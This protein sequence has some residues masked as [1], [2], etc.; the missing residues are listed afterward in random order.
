MDKFSR[1]FVRT[2]SVHFFFIFMEFSD[3]N[4]NPAR[5]RFNKL[6]AKDIELFLK[7]ISNYKSFK[8]N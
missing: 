7:S 5:R 8:I 4:G 3:I 2:L 6:S 1:T